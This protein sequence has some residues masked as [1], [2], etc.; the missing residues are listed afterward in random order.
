MVTQLKPRGTFYGGLLCG[1]YVY[2][3]HSGQ[4]ITFKTHI[5]MADMLTELEVQEILSSDSTAKYYPLGKL[6]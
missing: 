4:Q 5:S 6:F 3:A 2:H 1:T